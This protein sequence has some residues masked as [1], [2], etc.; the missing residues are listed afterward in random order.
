MDADLPRLQTST[1]TK[2]KTNRHQNWSQQKLAI[3]PDMLG[4]FDRSDVGSPPASNACKAHDP[5]PARRSRRVCREVTRNTHLENNQ[6]TND[7]IDDK[8]SS[9]KITIW[10]INRRCIDSSAD[11]SGVHHVSHFLRITVTWI[12]DR[13]RHSLVTAYNLCII[14]SPAVMESWNRATI[15][16][17]LIGS[18][19]QWTKQCHTLI[20]RLI[21]EAPVR[22]CWNHNWS[23]KA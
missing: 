10:T 6:A 22:E 17:Q 18:M 13:Q 23:C 4:R 8:K 14:S 3:S 12:L 19:Q 16:Q 11:Y 7:H 9:L 21:T 2:T 15:W 1:Q 5:N 20:A